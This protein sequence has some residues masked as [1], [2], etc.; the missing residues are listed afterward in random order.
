MKR[1]PPPVRIDIGPEPVWLV[2]QGLVFGST[3]SVLGVW[4]AALCELAMPWRWSAVAA[5]L[6]LGLLSIAVAWARA[7]D[8]GPLCLVFDGQLWSCCGSGQRPEPRS[9]TPVVALDFGRWMLLRLDPAPPAEGSARVGRMPD[10]MRRRWVALSRSSA[11]A[12][13]HALR[14]ALYCSETG[15]DR[16]SG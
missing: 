13:W 4:A 7:R 5:G 10:V 12:H 8:L 9:C 11:A 2:V 1:T 6:L 14:V 16:P 15:A 3:A